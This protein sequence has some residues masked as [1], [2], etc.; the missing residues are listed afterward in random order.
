MRKNFLRKIVVLALVAGVCGR[1][2]TKRTRRCG[3]A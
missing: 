1:L 2:Y 3:G